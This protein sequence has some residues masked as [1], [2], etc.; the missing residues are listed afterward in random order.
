MN[1]R[2]ISRFVIV[3]II[4][5]LIIIAVAVVTLLPQLTPTTTTT[6]TTT[7][8]MPITS[9]TI[10]TGTV[11]GVYIYYGGGM[12]TIY[13]KYLGIQAAAV[14]TKASVDNLL[15]IAK[16]P[17]NTIGLVLSDTIYDAWNGK[18]SAFNNTPQQWIRILWV[19][20]NN[21]I[22]IVTRSDSGIKTVYDL[23]GKRVSTGPPAS[24]TELTA[25]SI[26]KAAGIDP[27][28]DLAVWQKL[29][30]AESAGALLDGKL[31]AFFWSGGLPT[32]SIS[33]LS[34]NLKQRGLKI[35]FIAV[36]TEVFNKLD[37]QRPGIYVLATLKKEV[38][39]AVEDVQTMAVPNLIVAHKDMAD[40]T[41]Y[42]LVKTVFQHLDELQAVH[43]AAKDT[44]L[45][46]APLYKGAPYHPGAIRFYKEAKVWPSG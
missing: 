44:T 6:T 29:G 5:I 8:T 43:Q 26:L 23:K 18:L 39:D 30:P 1:K 17:S 38:Y 7:V 27:T 13:S 4:V 37:A 2:A 16:S 20:Y 31:D 3:G 19:M 24:G 33:E 46:S 35:A 32:G 15:Y 25:L 36:P 21:Y 42:L 41:A 11:G 34:V 10:A 12:A 40:D 45:E 14:Q 28:T 9:L 22:H